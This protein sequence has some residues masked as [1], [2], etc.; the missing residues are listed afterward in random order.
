MAIAGGYLLLKQI[1]VRTS[2]WHLWGYNTAGATLFPF[3]IGVGLLFAD[4]RSK[5]GWLLA[6]GS[7]IA[8][9]SGALFNLSVYFAST[10]LFNLLV[11]LVLLAGGVGLI[12]RSLREH[13]T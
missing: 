5:V 12:A 3:L 2:F 8:L 13:A 10:S 9:V 1:S 7:V 11:M 4:G 6:A